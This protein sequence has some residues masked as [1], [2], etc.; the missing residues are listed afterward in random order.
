MLSAPSRCF[1]SGAAIAAGAGR[2]VRSVIQA[3]GRFRI[4]VA[5]SIVALSALLLGARWWRQR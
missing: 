2:L 4:G 3:G 5:A 1:E